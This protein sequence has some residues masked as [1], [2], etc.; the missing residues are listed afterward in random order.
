MD[1]IPRAELYDEFAYHTALLSD[2][3]SGDWIGNAASLSA[4]LGRRRR[5][6]SL[7]GSLKRGGSLKGR[8]SLFAGTQQM[9]GSNRSTS[10]VRSFRATSRGGSRGRNSISGTNVF[11][12]AVKDN[13]K[14]KP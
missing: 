5:N 7:R 13:K 2:F 10:S 9:T 14:S 6:S 1:K 8:A 11:A 3:N 4:S 12:N